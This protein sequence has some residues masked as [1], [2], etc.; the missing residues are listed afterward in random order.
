MKLSPPLSQALFRSPGVLKDLGFLLLLWCLA[1]LL[2]NPYGNFP[3]NDDWSYGTTVQRLL[4]E[5]R[6]RPTGWTAM[7]LISQVLWGAL[8]CLP[9]GYSFTAL[10]VST[11]VLALLGVFAF[12]LLLRQV[13]GSRK[14]AVV[15]A[16]ILAFNPVYFSL[17][18]TFM[19]DVP[20]TT[21]TIIAL[22]FLIRN[23][24]FDSFSDLFWGT[25]CIAAAMLCRQLGFFLPVSFA[26]VLLAKYGFSLR[27]AV[28]AIPAGGVGMAGLLVLQYWLMVS[29]AVPSKYSSTLHILI[30]ALRRPH[31]LVFTIFEQL[32]VILIYLGLFLLPLTFFLSIPHRTDK[33]ARLAK[34]V[35]GLFAALSIVMLFSK[36]QLMPLGQ[37]ILI[38]GGVG[39]RTLRDTYLLELPHGPEFSV[40]FWLFVTIMAVVG[41][42]LLLIYTIFIVRSRLHEM[43]SCLRGGNRE[44]LSTIFFLAAIVLYVFPLALSGF[45]DRYLLPLIPLICG[46]MIASD[47][48]KERPQRSFFKK[49]ALC[50]LI[51]FAVF[52]VGSTREY[53]D[54]NRLRWKAL[55]RLL[56]DRQIL[57]SQI[58]GG[59]EFNGL[60]LYQ[61]TY[62]SIPSKSWWWVHDDA[63]MITMGDLEG[64]EVIQEYPFPH[65][66][67]GQKGSLLV[68]RRQD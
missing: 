51:V 33:S 6:Y 43:R 50:L 28:R 21:F 20:F 54:W 41:G 16:L 18:Q 24:L 8:F 13:G 47:S 25:C 2:V 31:T 22:L 11:L 39:P 14:I 44:L 52:S 27:W 42:G 9:F 15:A 32:C 56:Y 12:Y 10:R 66:L 5:G 40:I 45:F 61:S 3:L 7:P 36:S 57:P 37:N 58:D 48:V 26:L 60:Y 34:T 4:E 68:Q 38:K 23:V 59:F 63:Y 35:F 65:W 19:T 67:S 62:R 53:L 64:Y 30:Q 46:F 29:E 55:H 1:I 49:G 17:S